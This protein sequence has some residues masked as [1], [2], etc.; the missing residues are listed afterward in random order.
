MYEALKFM[1]KK[2]KMR[3]ARDILKNDAEDGSKGPMS[4]FQMS[5]ERGYHLH[6][7]SSFIQTKDS[8]ILLFALYCA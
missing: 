1:D 7:L 8:S 3:N 2:R 4:M 6:D 5:S